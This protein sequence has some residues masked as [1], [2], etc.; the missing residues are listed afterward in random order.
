MLIVLQFNGKTAC[1]SKRYTSQHRPRVLVRSCL[2]ANNLERNDLSQPFLLFLARGVLAVA[3]ILLRGCLLVA[4][5]QFVRALRPPRSLRVP[6]G[7]RLI[8]PPGSPPPLS[9]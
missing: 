7:L 2:E 5:L 8:P 1:V 3:R 4:G 9:P 6:G